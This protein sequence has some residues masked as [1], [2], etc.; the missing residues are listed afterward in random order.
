MRL[1]NEG[2][3]QAAPVHILQ[4]PSRRWA[5]QDLWEYRSK[6]LVQLWYWCYALVLEALSRLPIMNGRVS[7][8]RRAFSV[9]IEW[10]EI[11]AAETGDV[12]Y[13][14]WPTTVGCFSRGSGTDVCPDRGYRLIWTGRG[15]CPSISESASPWRTL[16]ED[17]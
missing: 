17:S 16:D 11:T 2:G 10:G 3:L 6:D 13:D 9:S 14:L 8:L 5:A 7:L 1:G 4:K 15:G 12:Q